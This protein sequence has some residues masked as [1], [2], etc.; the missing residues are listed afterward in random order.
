M[1][2]PSYTFSVTDGRQELLKTRPLKKKNFK[3]FLKLPA[4]LHL[5]PIFSPGVLLLGL[6]DLTRTK[7][8]SVQWMI[9]ISYG[10]ETLPYYY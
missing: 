8:F 1:I 9:L 2:S 3:V 4:G 5:H 7:K 6:K 10:F